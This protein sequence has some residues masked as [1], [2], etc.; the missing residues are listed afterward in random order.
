MVIKSSERPAFM[1]QTIQLTPRGESMDYG[2]RVRHRP[3]APSRKY[4]KTNGSLFNANS[5]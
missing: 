4:S 3:D 2:R 5:Q 1:A